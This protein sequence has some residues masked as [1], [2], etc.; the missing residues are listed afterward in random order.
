MA[1]SGPVVDLQPARALWRDTSAERMTTGRREIV[2]L[3]FG[4]CSLKDGPGHSTE[5][6]G[7]APS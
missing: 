7:T 1:P 6:P 3:R 5:R 2:L 4:V